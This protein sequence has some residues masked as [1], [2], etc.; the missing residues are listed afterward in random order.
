MWMRPKHP[1]P[2]KE[3]ALHIG[4]HVVKI[5]V[6][7]RGSPLLRQRRS[8]S[9]PAYTYRLAVLPVVCRQEA[10]PN[11]E[12]PDMRLPAAD[13]LHDCLEKA[14]GETGAHDA[15]VARDRVGE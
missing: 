6:P 8:V 13:V 2:R 9:Y 14:A 12:Q 10:A 3:H 4:F 7:P 1:H 5:Y 11:L 15:H